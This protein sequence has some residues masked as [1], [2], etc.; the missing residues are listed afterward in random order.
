MLTLAPP[1]VE[2]GGR[3]LG[4]MDHICISYIIVGGNADLVGSHFSQTVAELAT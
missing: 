1:D 3:V 4:H 2:G